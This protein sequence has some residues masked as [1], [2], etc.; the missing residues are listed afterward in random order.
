MHQSSERNIS[1]QLVNFP[2]L[3]TVIIETTSL[4]SILYMDPIAY[5]FC[6]IHFDIIIPYTPWHSKWFFHVMFLDQNF[7]CISFMPQRA[8][9]WDRSLFAIPLSVPNFILDLGYCSTLTLNISGI[10]FCTTA[11]RA[12]TTAKQDNWH[13]QFHQRLVDV[14]LVTTEDNEWR[15]AVVPQASLP[16][17]HISHG[18]KTTEVATKFELTSPFWLAY[19]SFIPRGSPALQMQC[20]FL[21]V[22]IGLDPYSHPQQPSSPSRCSHRGIV[23]LMWWSDVGWLGSFW[24]CRYDP[25]VSEEPRLIG[26]Y[27]VWIPR[28]GTEK[29]TL[30]PSVSW[31]VMIT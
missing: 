8:T 16:W 25:W 26:K 14:T 24:E 19:P 28:A 29:C 17:A 13:Q 2:V 22:P 18:N 3:I 1:F 15:I 6:K 31:W 9:V 11:I 4:D 20:G 30:V 21:V 23:R 12:G 27:A 10:I 5:Y 7:L